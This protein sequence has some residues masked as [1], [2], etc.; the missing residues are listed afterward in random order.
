M[1]KSSKQALLVLL[2]VMVAISLMAGSAFATNGYFSHGFGIKYK[3]LAGAGVALHLGPMAVATNPGAMAFIGKRYDITLSFFN[4]NRQY[5]VVGNP[6]G[7]QRTFGLVPGTYES[8]SKMFY[9]PSLAANWVLNEDETIALGVAVYG[10]GGMN[11]DYPTAT[12]DPANMFENTT[13]T[14]VNIMQLFVAPTLSI[15][16]AEAHGFGLTPLFAYQSFEAKGLQAFGAFGFSSAPDKLTNNDASSSTGYGFRVGYLGE[17]MDFLAVGASYQSKIKMGKFDEYAGLFAEQGGFD[18]P[19]NWTAGVALGFEAMG[20]ALDVQQIMYS[21]VKA[22]ANP[23][24]P[25]IQQAQLGNDEGAGFGWEDM[26][27][28]KGGAYYQSSGGWTWRAGYS[29]GKQPI[30]ESEV[31]FNILAPGVVEQHITFGFTKA[32]NNGKEIN[33]SIMRALSNTVSGP[34]PL[35]IPNQQTIDLKMDQW[36]LGLGFSF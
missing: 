4:P 3:S 32:L 11:T 29:Y 19:A 10:N 13:P 31:M 18:I 28:I 25:N 21:Q 14:G 34:N 15:K 27:V 2:N 12:F 30:P 36:E 22:I 6:S 33:I 24:I 26:T 17:L 23:I 1:Q 16:V 9:V 7:I 8:D 5:N 35:E 20:L